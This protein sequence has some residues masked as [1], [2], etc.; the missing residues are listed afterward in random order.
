MRAPEPSGRGDFNIF[1]G[2]ETTSPS[3]CTRKTLHGNQENYL[4]MSTGHAGN[5][6]RVYTNAFCV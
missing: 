1:V 4:L 3:L 2:V 5:T 6:S